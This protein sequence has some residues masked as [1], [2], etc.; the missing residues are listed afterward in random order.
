MVGPISI[1]VVED[2]DDINNLL[3]SVL[4]ARGYSPQPAF[5]GT[6]AQ[7]Y[8]A[9]REWALVLLDLMLPGKRGEELLTEISDKHAYPV[10]V[11]SAQNDREPKIS[12][13][14]TGADD[15]IT[16]PFDLEEVS[17]R[18]ESV[19]R[20]HR[21]SAQA[22]RAKSM[23]HKGLLLDLEA[24]T[25]A[26]GETELTLTAREFDILALLMA[27]PKKLFTKANLFESVWGEAFLGGSDNIVNVH[28]SNLR[29]K[30][31]KANPDVEYIETIWGMGYRL[32]S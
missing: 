27:S 14:K 24:M 25:A 13:L 17:A 22:Q 21:K 18:I 29:G 15:Y 9:E 4:R 7:R 19:L 1:L 32:K 30:L 26:I 5:S 10:I 3:C 20:R 16:K 6:E 31:A 11:I 23:Q 12:A 2:D 28:M 8:L